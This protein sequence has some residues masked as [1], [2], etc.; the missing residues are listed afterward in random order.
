MTNLAETRPIPKKGFPSV[1]YEANGFVAEELSDLH[2]VA[3]S[4][5]DHAYDPED[6]TDIHRAA[7]RYYTAV[8]V[9]LCF[10]ALDDG[11]PP[12]VG[13]LAKAFNAAEVPKKMAKSAWT[14]ANVH[15]L[16]L[17]AGVYN[18]FLAY[19]NSENESFTTWFSDGAAKWC[20]ASPT[21]RDQ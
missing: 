8:L 1:Y 10:R 9:S 13:E 7:G 18:D 12:S 21:I 4:C 11:M 5:L 16:L 20:N 19:R 15:K 14:G 17:R 6:N 2:P 3:L